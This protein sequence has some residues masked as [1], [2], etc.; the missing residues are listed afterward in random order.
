MFISNDDVTCNHLMPAFSAK[1][2]SSSPYV[3]GEEDRLVEGLVMYQAFM[4][5]TFFHTNNKLNQ[6][7]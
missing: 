5:Q 4:Q 6:V 1:A 3:M 7:L 2:G